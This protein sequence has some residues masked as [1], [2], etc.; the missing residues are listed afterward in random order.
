MSILND[1]VSLWIV[2][3]IAA[4]LI[5]AW[6]FVVGVLT[7]RRL[8]PFPWTLSKKRPTKLRDTVDPKRHGKDCPCE[9]CDNLRDLMYR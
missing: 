8:N 6:G 7:E 3:S 2:V 1:P 9:D 5:A 4:L